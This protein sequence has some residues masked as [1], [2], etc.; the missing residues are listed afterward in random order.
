MNTTYWPWWLGAL[1]LAGV[2]VG[3]TVAVGR[4][5]GVSG[6]VQKALGRPGEPGEP[7]ERRSSLL[8]LGGLVLGGLIAAATGGGLEVQAQDAVQAAFFGPGAG[9]LGALFGGGLLVGFGTALAGGCTS[10]H[11]LLG[12][13]RLQPGS[14]LATATFFGTAVGLSLLL[15]AFF[16]EV[17]R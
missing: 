10:G 11:G 17:S 3:Y 1:A 9:T 2:A 14:L 4:P 15:S 13:A 8:F 12:C 16:G 7:N 5:L 6:L